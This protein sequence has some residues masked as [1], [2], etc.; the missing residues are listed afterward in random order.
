MA[1]N[2]IMCGYCRTIPPAAVVWACKWYGIVALK[3]YI[4]LL[5]SHTKEI[6]VTRKYHVVNRVCSLNK[7]VFLIFCP[8]V[9]ENKQSVK[10]Y[11]AELKS[12]G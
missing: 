6:V 8:I 5:L 3:A 11:T 10:L 9:F 2:V 1:L 7:N 12:R 4:I